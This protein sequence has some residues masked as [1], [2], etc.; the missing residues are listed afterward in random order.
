M[1]FPRFKDPQEANIFFC[2]KYPIYYEA[3][4]TIINLVT[5]EL[6]RLGDNSSRFLADYFFIGFWNSLIDN[7]IPED[8]SIKEHSVRDVLLVKLMNDIKKEV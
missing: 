8:L 7:G 1:E 2:M 3:Y 6:E 4:I 5:D